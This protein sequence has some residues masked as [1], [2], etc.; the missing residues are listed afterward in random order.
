MHVVACVSF[1]RSAKGCATNISFRHGESG[2]AADDSFR[3]GENSF[4]KTLGGFLLDSPY[5]A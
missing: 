3:S 1:R 5:L 4:A 2:C